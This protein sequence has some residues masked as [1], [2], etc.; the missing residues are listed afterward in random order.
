MRLRAIELFQDH[1]KSGLLTVLVVAEVIWVVSA[2]SSSNSLPSSSP[3]R[4]S[5]QAFSAVAAPVPTNRVTGRG[6]ATL[7]F[8]GTAATVTVNATG[9]LDGSPH[10]MHIHAGGLGACPPA[11]AA[12]LHNGHLSI[13]T[14]DGDRFYGPTVVSLTET[15]ST[16]GHVPVNI[17]F[18]RY[19][20]SGTIHYSRTVVLA[21]GVA[22]L[23]RHGSATIVIHGID[24]NG[25]HFYDFG[26]LGASA[27]D[28]A[29]SGEAT[30]P[31]LCGVLRPMQRIQTVTARH[32]GA[33]SQPTS[34]VASLNALTTRP[35]LVRRQPGPAPLAEALDRVRRERD[36]KAVPGQ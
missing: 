24:Y 27:P 21:S 4:P 2:F 29:L 32:A 20:S 16:N 19:P 34:Y 25:N 13:S 9:L 14:V 28:T 22:D 17:D 12:R 6:T 7:Q 10:L 36:G 8:R 30:A 3:S 11:S 31:A 18:K 23:I 1:W 26:A 15:G 5:V 33:A 35:N